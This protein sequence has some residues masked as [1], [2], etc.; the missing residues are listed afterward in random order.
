MDL[1]GGDPRT[2]KFVTNVG[3]IT[4]DGPH[5]ENIM[6][7]EWTSQ[8][9]YRPGMIAIGLGPTKATLENIRM[10]KQ[11]GVSLAA[12]D[13][14]LLSSISGSNTG[15]DTQKVSALQEL[16]FSFSKGEKTGLPLVAG[17]A[18][19]AECKVVDEVVTGDHV[20]VIGEVLSAEAG[21]NDPLVLHGGQYWKLTT[22]LE[23]VPQDERDRAQ[24]VVDKH[25][26]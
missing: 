9:S 19:R 10:T 22:P 23:K 4:S 11:F 24:S 13:H 16:G 25:R 7:C 2:R 1:P 14:P 12:I 17:A 6:A 5:G 18:M 3:L 21:E 20:L 15:R 26:K 8:V